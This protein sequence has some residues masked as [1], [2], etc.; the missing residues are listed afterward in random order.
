ME[1]D[2]SKFAKELIAIFHA[3]VQKEEREEREREPDSARDLNNLC[4]SF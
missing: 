4:S 2:L 3:S 1:I